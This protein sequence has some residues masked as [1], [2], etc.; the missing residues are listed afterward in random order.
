MKL[1]ASVTD[2]VSGRKLEVYTTE[3]GLQFYSGNYLNEGII[4]NRDGKA[5]KQ[6][7]GFSLET[8]HYPDAPNR[9]DFPSVILKPGDKY[10]SETRYK[11]SIA[12]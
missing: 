5:I 2:S 3:P 11:V 6:H 4:I 12:R 7:T 8:Q 10:H 9:P 1:V